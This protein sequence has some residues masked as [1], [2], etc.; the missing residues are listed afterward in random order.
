MFGE[1]PSRV[2][3]S[4]DEEQVDA[5][6]SRASAAGVPARLLGATGG[7]RVRIRVD[8]QDAIDLD[9]MEAEHAWRS[10]VERYFAQQVA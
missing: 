10:G 9:V 8:G 4:V 6:L 7:N 2:I 3:V 1:T 5:L